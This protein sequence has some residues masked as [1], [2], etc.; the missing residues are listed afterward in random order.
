VTKQNIALYLELSQHDN[1]WQFDRKCLQFD[2]VHNVIPWLGHVFWEVGR[3]LIVHLD[4]RE[5][6]LRAGRRDHQTQQD[7]VT[8]LPLPCV[9][10][11][12]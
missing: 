9:C 3:E 7:H 2:H 4:E 1:V 5:E 12:W 8:I 6:G 11:G 10:C